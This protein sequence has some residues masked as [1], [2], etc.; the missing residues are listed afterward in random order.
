MSESTEVRIDASTF[1][2]PLVKLAEVLA[3][4]V[5]REAP[6][7]GPCR[8]DLHILIRQS[9]WTYDLLFYLNADERRETDCY[10]RNG[11]TIV[12]M[13][14]V[15]NMIDCLYNT[16]LILQDPTAN[17]RWFRAS[18]F[19]RMINGIE[20][21]EQRYGGQADWDEWNLKRRDNLDLG[22]RTSGMKVADIPSTRDW[23][24]L[25]RYS[26]MP[27]KGATF[28]PH[29]HFFKTFLL[30][31]WRQ[32]SAMAHATFEGLTDIALCYTEDSLPVDERP[33]L[34]DGY[35]K[36]RSAT[37]GRAATVLLCLITELQAHFHFDDNG[38][39]IN[40][41][42]HEMWGALMP[43]FDVKE[44]YDER[45]KQLMEDREI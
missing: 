26:K 29:Q 18:G 42:I 2:K 15:R 43:S 44:L 32:Y 8:V 17:G 22:V 23:P 38:A 41:R 5:L 1:Q 27:G 33:K 21:D 13:P 16:T 35:S 31:H 10:W 36:L 40:E 14:L 45:Y 34:D 6:I 25:G 28:T 4:K 24:T 9:M 12:T 7:T 11:Y 30:G 20:E 39:R 19:K 37:I 3:Q